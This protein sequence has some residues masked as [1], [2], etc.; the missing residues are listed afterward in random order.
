[1][2]HNEPR[3]V[4][5]AELKAK[6]SEYL[7]GARRGRTVTVLDRETP[8]A[9]LVPM[10]STELLSV[11]P[12]AGRHRSLGQVPLPPPVRLPVDPVS[13]LLEDRESGR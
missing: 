10:A 12:R 3:T 5:V 8:V 11:R 6:L 13:L 9:Q 4:G 2:E 1:M 7:R